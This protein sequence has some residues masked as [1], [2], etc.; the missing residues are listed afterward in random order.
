[1][2]S[3]KDVLGRESFVKRVVDL[4]RLISEKRTSCCFAIEGEWGSGKSFVLEKVQECLQEEQS[5]ATGA[6]RFFVVRYDCWKYDYY[7]EPVIAIISVLREKIEQYISLLTDNVKKTLLLNVKNAITKI[8]VDAIKSKTGIDMSGVIEAPDR[9]D[10]IY[11]KYFGF[12]KVIDR[13]QNQIE[14]ISQDQTVVIIV[15]ELDRCLPSYTIKVLERIHHMFNELENVVII[16]A[17]EKKQISNSLHQIYGDEMDVDR[18]LKKIISFGFKLD[19]GSASNFIAKY[20]SYFELFDI[21]DS[22]KLEEFLGEITANIDIRTQEKIFEKAENLHRLMASQIKMGTEVLAVEILT[23]CV[24]EKMSQVDLKWLVNLS[25][26]PGI[27][28]EVG[29]D[30]FD[31]VRKYA[32]H[33]AEYPIKTNGKFICDDKSFVDRMVFI[34]AGL[35]NEYKNNVCDTFY[36]A[37]EEIEKEVNFTRQIYELLK[38]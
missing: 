15:D 10:K 35:T 31:T 14:K 2:I 12:Q 5:E 38:M 19:N 20:A 36:C 37:D 34:I 17:M 7:E 30:Y 32:K 25:G 11:D 9:D 6:D 16:V 22:D 27:E 3:K 29:K 4:T 23:L 24:K 8:A 26:Y 1:M 21:K 33:I 13:V 28:K 18:Y